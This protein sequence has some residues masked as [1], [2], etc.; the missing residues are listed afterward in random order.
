MT[1]TTPARKASA[2]KTGASKSA[3]TKSA[4]KKPPPAQ[5][6]EEPSLR[7]FHSQAL[8]DQTLAVLT[9]IENTPTTKGKA[10]ADLVDDLVEA[11]ME[12]YFMR[13]L[14]AAEVGFIKEQSARLGMT[15][16][17]KIVSSV[18]RKYI[19]GMD[20]KQLLVVVAHIRSLT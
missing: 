7:F 12:Y 20:H 11:G 1:A 9:S 13:P 8:R 19:E 3:T 6:S 16:A 17:V 18:C 10:L 4:E 2:A 14:K 5:A 15:G